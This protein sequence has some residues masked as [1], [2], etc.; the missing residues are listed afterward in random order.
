VA[1][2]EFVSQARDLPSEAYADAEF[3]DRERT[4][5]FVNGWVSVAVTRQL[6]DAGDVLPVDVAGQPLIITRSADT[7]I[8]VFYNVCR[9]LGARLALVLVR[10]AVWFDT[11]YVNLSRDAQPFEE[12]IAPLAKHWSEFDPDQLRLLVSKEYQPD[13]N[14]KLVCENSLGGYHVPW[15]HHQV[16]PPEAGA[17]FQTVS[18]TDGIFGTFVPQ[19]QAERPRIDRP[20]PRFASVSDEFRGSHHFIYVSPNTLLAIGGQRFQVISVLPETRTTSRENLALYLVNDAAT[21]DSRAEQHAEFG[22]QMLCINE[23]DMGIVQRLQNGRASLGA[24]HCTFAPHWDEL[25]A[26][27]QQRMGKIH[28]HMP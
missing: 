15:V 22:K 10:F 4:E 6:P 7:S 21:E 16:G 9:H 14:W 11:I 3:F 28:G 19:G 2:A 1:P 27:F 18:L 8:H 24:E 20:L 12:F 5:A 17:D 23:Q 13:A 25:L 26:L